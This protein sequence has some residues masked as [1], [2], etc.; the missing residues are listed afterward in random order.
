MKFFG[1]DKAKAL[2]RIE[3]LSGSDIDQPKGNAVRWLGSDAGAVAGTVDTRAPRVSNKFYPNLESLRGI[4]SL[5]VVFIHCIGAFLTINQATGFGEAVVRHFFGAVNGRNAVVLFFVLSGFVLSQSLSG[6]SGSFSRRYGRFVAK[7]AFRILPLAYAVLLISFIFLRWYSPAIPLSTIGRGWLLVGYFPPRIADLAN[8]LVFVDYRM[9]GVYWTLYIEILG[10]LA[11]PLLFVVS[12][13][14]G[15]LGNVFALILL[16]FASFAAGT[17]SLFP[18]FLF[19]F[20]VGCICF[21][22]REWADRNATAGLSAAVT[23]VVL[24]AL[25]LYI[26]AYVHSSLGNILYAVTGV[27]PVGAGHL[28]VQVP[29]E[30]LGAAILIFACSASRCRVLEII[31][32][33]RLLRGLGRI[34]Y[35]LYAVHLIVLKAIFPLIVLSL[36]DLL[37]EA[38]LLGPT[39]ALLTV[40]PISIALAAVAYRYVERPG[41]AL[42]KWA[43][44]RIMHPHALP[45]PERLVT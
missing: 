23:P 3:E 21:A 2:P 20:Y 8:A 35:S 31:F 5:S 44:T 29:L 22:L 30:A 39:L 24:A 37:F 28:W 15:A 1:T 42:G 43:S 6:M 40:V 11:M 25:G 33:N 18:Q 38:P 13:S 36:G 19:C 12:K 34:S 45:H 4:A 7:R 9:N 26:L 14:V 41:I 10:S 27:R 16:V 17:S 32:G